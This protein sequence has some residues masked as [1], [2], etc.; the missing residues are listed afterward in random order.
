MHGLCT[1][2]FGTP[3]GIVSSIMLTSREVNFH[4]KAAECRNIA[5]VADFLALNWTAFDYQKPLEE[6]CYSL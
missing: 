6:I 2:Q 4:S 3:M 1:D 5:V